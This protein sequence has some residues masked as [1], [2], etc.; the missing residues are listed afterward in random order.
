MCIPALI[1]DSDRFAAQSPIGANYAGLYG[2]VARTVCKRRCNNP[3]IAPFPSR[4][5]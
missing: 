5:A 1:K 2:N 4:H 3:R